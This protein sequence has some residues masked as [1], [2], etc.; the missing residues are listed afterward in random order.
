MLKSVDH[1]VFVVHCL[2]RHIPR[3]NP[4]DRVVLVGHGCGRRHSLL[5]AAVPQA[6]PTTCFGR[7][8]YHGRLD[9]Q[10]CYHAP[11]I[12]VSVYVV[13]EWECSFN[14]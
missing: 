7:N 9:A 3:I 5:G 1:I 11:S 2:E 8:F 10:V 13:F 14:I 4:S 12:Q 6:D